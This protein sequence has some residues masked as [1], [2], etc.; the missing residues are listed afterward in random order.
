MKKLVAI[1]TMLL[2]ATG[3]TQPDPATEKNAVEGA[4]KGFYAAAQKND[5][6]A[7][8]SFCTPDFAGF[9]DGQAF[10]FDGFMAMFQTVEPGTFKPVLDFVRTDCGRDLS[11]SIVKFDA[12]LVMN[13]KPLHLKTYE[14]YILKKI[15]GKWLICAYHSTHLNGPKQLASGCILGLHTLGKIDLKPGVTL[16]QV[17]DFWLNRFIPAFNQLT[18]ELQTIPLR[19]Q[20]GE[21]KDQFGYIFYIAS[22]QVRNSYWE[23]EGKQTQKA[24]DLFQKLGPVYEEQSKLYSTTTDPYTDWKVY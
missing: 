7:L 16:A 23:A 9:E 12:T 3:C 5:V 15:D 20:R 10:D 6:A 21:G 2:L 13:K 18:D 19:G 24:I 11:H 17:E 14:N 22:E 4:I 1:A 8:K